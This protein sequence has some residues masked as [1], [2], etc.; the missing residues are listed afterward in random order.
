MDDTN[1]LSGALHRLTLDDLC[2]TMPFRFLDLPREIRDEIYGLVLICDTEI[3]DESQSSVTGSW[4]DRKVFCRATFVKHGVSTTLLLTNH[5]IYD[6]A[7]SV[8]LAGNDFVRITSTMWEVEESIRGWCVPIIATGYAA[9]H[10]KYPTLEAFFDL[11]DDSPTSGIENVQEIRLCA[12]L[13]L[14]CHLPAFTESY[15]GELD[16]MHNEDAID[17]LCGSLRINC[18]LGVLVTTKKQ[19]RFLASFRANLYDFQDFSFE[20]PWDSDLIRAAK[21]DLARK[22]S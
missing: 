3:Q 17:P 1:T 21:V 2:K 10:F 9:A 5:Q 18:P 4:A 19:E 13:I 15:T 8:M 11:K 12:I 22:Q 16:L 20:G 6:E 14:A 7:R